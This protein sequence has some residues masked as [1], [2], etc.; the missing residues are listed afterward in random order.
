MF[1]IRYAVSFGLVA[2]LLMPIAAAAQKPAE[3][4]V[5]SYYG[6]QPAEETI[7]YSMYARIREEGLRH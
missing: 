2:G 1:S 6:P 5:P 7:D 4:K 3:K